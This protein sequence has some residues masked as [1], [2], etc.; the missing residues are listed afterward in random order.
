MILSYNKIRSLESFPLHVGIVMKNY[1][2]L[3]WLDLSH[4]YLTTLNYDF[5]D[6]KNLKSLYLHCNYLKDIAELLK[7][8]HLPLIS[9][10]IHGNPIDTIPAFRLYII[11]LLPQL[12]RIDSVLISMKERDNGSFLVGPNKKL[13]KPVEKAQEPPEENQPNNNEAGKSN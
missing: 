1:D 11:Q 7:I 2:Q 13:P 10:T 8:R 5:K 9:L 6:L 4:N 3:Q 12:K